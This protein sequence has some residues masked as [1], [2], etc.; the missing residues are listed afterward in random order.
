MQYGPFAEKMS[1]AIRIQTLTDQ[2]TNISF[3]VNKITINFRKG[4]KVHA[5]IIIEH[6]NLF[7]IRSFIKFDK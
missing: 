6:R 2:E 1:D 7:K 3:L 5:I 4:F